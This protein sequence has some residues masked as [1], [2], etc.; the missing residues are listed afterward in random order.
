MR[1]SVF[2]DESGIDRA[3]DIPDID[4][5]IIDEGSDDGDELDRL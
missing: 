4:V 5:D 2:E 1:T 3:G